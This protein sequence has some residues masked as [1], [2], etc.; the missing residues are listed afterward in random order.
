MNP[1]TAASSSSP[2]TE[3][4]RRRNTAFMVVA[5]ALY[6]ASLYLYVPTLPTYVESKADNLA[7]VGVVLSMYGLWQAIF[8]FPLG[9]ISDWVGKR[10]P[11]IIAGFLLSGLG[12][13]VIGQA[14][15]VN[16]L[17]LGR[18]ISGLAASSWVPLVVLFSSQF[19]PEEA[20]KASSLLNLVGSA[21]RVLATGATG[22]LN[23]VGGYS[24]AFF[25]ASGA[26]LLAVMVIL[27]SREAQLPKRRTSPQRVLKLITR[28]EVLLPSILALV[29]QY[30]NWGTTFSLNP[31]LAKQLGATDV[32]L[33]LILSMNALA[34]GLG[35]LAATMLA[36][37]VGAR[38]L[39]YT[40]FALLAS[41]IAIVAL[42]PWLWLFFAAQTVIGFS[43]GISYPVLM[44][45]SIRYVDESQ[46][47]TAMGLHQTVYAFG[48]FGGPALSGVIADQI[49]IR[50]T[51]GITAIVAIVLGIA[52]MRLL[53]RHVPDGR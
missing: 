20:V 16:G 17:L 13:L 50:P 2:I 1:V 27:P 5:I 15:D 7:M 53:V 9:I 14:R 43:Q 18:A 24:L 19:P 22:T 8:R 25:V 34:I 46:R 51:Q 38:A 10:K 33:S 35:S 47:T 3:R 36:N 40:G 42:T 32:T 49:G 44:G 48:M 26:A 37:K 23:G 4:A 39:V 12:A 6:W 29:A 41:G 28:P 31:I 11:F 45:L 52:L 21:S 30:A